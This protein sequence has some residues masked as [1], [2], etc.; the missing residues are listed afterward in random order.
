[1][2]RAHDEDRLD[3]FEYARMIAFCSAMPYLEKGTTLQQFWSIPTRDNNEDQEEK[4]NDVKK[5][6][7]AITAKYKEF[8]NR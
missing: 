1:M 8:Y 6:T 4:I 7:D 2:W 5:F 3:H